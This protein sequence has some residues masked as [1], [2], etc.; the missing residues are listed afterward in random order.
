MPC[1]SCSGETA[2]KPFE[3]LFWTVGTTVI[4]LALRQYNL[5]NNGSRQALFKY[6]KEVQSLHN[7]KVFHHL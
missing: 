6:N 4:Q 2:H 1:E 7:R 3:G 5:E